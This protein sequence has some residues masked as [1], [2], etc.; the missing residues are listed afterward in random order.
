MAFG[1]VYAIRYSHLREIPFFDILKYLAYSI[2]ILFSFKSIIENYTWDKFHIIFFGLLTIIPV[3]LYLKYGSIIILSTVLILAAYNIPYSHIVDICIKSI[4]FCFSIV[5]VCLSMGIIN[6]EL[7]YR[8]V[9]FFERSY[10]HSLGFRYYAHYAY[11]GIGL[12]CCLVYKWRKRMTILRLVILFLISTSFFLL[13]STRLQLYACVSFIVAVLFLQIIPKFLFRMKLMGLIAVIV[14]PLICIIVYIS[15][16]YRLLHLLNN[17]DD[18]NKMMSQ[19]LRLNEEAFMYYDATLWGNKLEFNMDR[20]KDYFYI[21]SGYLHILLG[22]GVVFMIILMLLYS[23]LFF[24]TYKARNYVLS[25]FLL[26]YSFLCISNG[27][28]LSL[29]ANPIVLLALSDKKTIKRMK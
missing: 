15:S 7:F 17:Y 6:D 19:R 3:F 20:G 2:V 13:S 29:L 24:K 23:I 5:L 21:D 8:D 11:L 18:L 10:A 27:L 1:A 16:K 9:D 22:C 4:L 25:V 28:L 14:Y 26:I 12:V